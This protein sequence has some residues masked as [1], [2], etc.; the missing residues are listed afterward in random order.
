[1]KAMSSEQRECLAELMK[2]IQGSPG[3]AVMEEVDRLKRGLRAVKRN[4]DELVTVLKALEQPG[5]AVKI[6]GVQRRKELQFALEE[7]ARLLHN[8]LSSAS[9]VLD[10]AEA[11]RKRLYRSSPFGQEITAEITQ[12]FKCDDD[13][14]VAEKLRNFVMHHDVAP[15]S[16]KMSW[17]AGEPEMQ[18]AF[19]LPTAEVARWLQR[20]DPAQDALKRMGKSINVL[21]F[22]DR[23]FGKVESFHV[24]LWQRQSEFHREELANTAR[25]QEQAR[26][27]LQPE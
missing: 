3:F 17:Q 2:Q 14:L 25:L 11:Q 18:N 6:R 10:Y 9:A 22:V 20:N 5:A 7:I 19:Q 4:R 8:F 24:W 21:S 27:M 26:A 13:Y 15:V 16:W 23:Y 12:R 1:M